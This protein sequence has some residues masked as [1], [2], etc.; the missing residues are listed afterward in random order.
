MTSTKLSIRMMQAEELSVAYDDNFAFCGLYIVA[1]GYRCK[2]YGLE[3]T[4]HRLN[5]CAV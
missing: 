4:R 1:P 2:G 5:Y 3:L